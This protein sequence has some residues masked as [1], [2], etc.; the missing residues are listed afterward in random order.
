[1]HCFSYHNAGYD[2]GR[3]GGGSC[4]ITAISTFNNCGDRCRSLA[5]R[6]GQIV[7][8]IVYVQLRAQGTK[9]IV[10][11]HALPDGGLI[12]RRSVLTA[13][14]DVG[15]DQIQVHLG[16]VGLSQSKRSSGTTP[17]G[18]LFPICHEPRHEQKL[19]G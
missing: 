1:M 2:S 18:G 11:K 4:V 17:S 10:S 7:C 15:G 6:P 19:L 14:W 5:W 8:F 16:V 3:R 12:H 9:L 13:L